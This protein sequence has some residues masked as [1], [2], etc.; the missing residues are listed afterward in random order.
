MDAKMNTTSNKVNIGPRFSF[1]LHILSTS[2]TCQN[3][4][5][6]A[7]CTS[8]NVIL[9]HTL[10]FYIDETERRLADRFREHLRNVEGNDM[11]ASKPVARHSNLLYSPTQHRSW[12]VAMA[13][14]FLS[15]KWATTAPNKLID[16]QHNKRLRREIPFALLRQ[17]YLLHSLLLL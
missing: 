12:E 8:A 2:R 15:F 9:P 11:D 4:H 17:C 6:K 3:S 1:Y 14:L 7:L 13:I 10:H 5:V 16:S